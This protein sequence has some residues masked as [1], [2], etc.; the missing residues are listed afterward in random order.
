MD[1]K[2]LVILLMS[3]V[4]GCES[5]S[6]SESESKRSYSDSSH[7]VSSVSNDSII[8]K[9][10]NELTQSRD[11]EKCDITALAEIYTDLKNDV[12]IDNERM[13]VL[14]CLNDSSCKNDVEF[15][16]F[17]NETLFLALESSTDTF[18]KQLSQEDTSVYKLISKEI[19]APVSD[20]I[21][22][23]FIKEKVIESSSD[24]LVKRWIISDLEFAI[25][26]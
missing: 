20:M 24:S 25:N 17:I 16:Q 18:L 15:N 3:F 2:I 4:T 14:F 9:A 26:K 10:K 6:G 11:C 21:D 23:E 7:L 19:H 12:Q 22:L 13:G 1:T 8:D 5:F